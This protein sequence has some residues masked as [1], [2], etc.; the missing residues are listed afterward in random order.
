MLLRARRNTRHAAPATRVRPSPVER[1]QQATCTPCDRAG[2]KRPTRPERW[3]R[4]RVSPLRGTPADH[5]AV[6]PSSHQSR[7]NPPQPHRV[8]RLTSDTHRRRRRSCPKTDDRSLTAGVEDT[9]PRFSAFRRNQMHRSLRAGLPPQRHPLSG[10]LTL[11]AVSSRCTLV[12][13]F[14]ATSTH[15]L[16]GSSELFPPQSAVMPLGIRCSL[17][18]R[19]SR[20]RSNESIASAMCEHSRRRTGWHVLDIAG[21]PGFRAFLR[22]GVRHSVRRVNAEQS[23]CSPDL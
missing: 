23:R 20:T 18:I 9:F 3:P 1:T 2:R 6:R 12:A 15:R 8:A 5:P 21:G 7:T 10:F 19:H 16:D 14:Q 11:P 17:A 4:F 13:V 22:P